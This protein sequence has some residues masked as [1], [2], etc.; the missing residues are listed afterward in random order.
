MQTCIKTK[1]WR[2]LSDEEN[3]LI[4]E[5]AGSSFQKTALLSL[6]LRGGSQYVDAVLA[7]LRA[8]KASSGEMS[9]SEILAQVKENILTKNSARILPPL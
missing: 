7:L 2:S 5:F 4:N 8:A 3:A 6:S 1:G 9:P